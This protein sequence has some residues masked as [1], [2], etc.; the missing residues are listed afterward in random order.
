MNAYPMEN[1]WD[2]LAR[3]GFRD[4][5][6][7]VQRKLS[8]SVLSLKVKNKTIDERIDIWLEG[9]QL[10]MDRWQNLLADIK[11]TNNAGF[12]TYSVVLRELFDFAQAG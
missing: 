11:S 12:V 8:T 10:L 3:S 7:R 5:L 9:H 2:E 1:Q 4:D 6:D